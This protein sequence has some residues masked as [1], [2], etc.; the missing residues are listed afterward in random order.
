[1]YNV[2]CKPI[3]SNDVF[4]SMHLHR[5]P[6]EHA[7]MTFLLINFIILMLHMFKCVASAFSYNRSTTSFVSQ[8][9]SVYY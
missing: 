9:E 1:M 4:D 5:I 2:N 8:S 7:Q 3:K 6:T